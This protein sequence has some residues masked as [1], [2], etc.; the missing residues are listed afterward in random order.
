MGLKG[1]GLFMTTLFT[2]PLTGIGLSYVLI[3][4]LAWVFGLP[5]RLELLPRPSSADGGILHIDSAPGGPKDPQQG[6][7]ERIPRNGSG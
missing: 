6:S 7:A 2:G 3:L 5:P 4:V 1:N